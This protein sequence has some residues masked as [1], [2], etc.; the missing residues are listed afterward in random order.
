VALPRPLEVSAGGLR[1]DALG[2]L[3]A[4]LRL[5]TT[6]PPG[7]ER[8]AAELLRRYLESAGVECRLYARVHERASLVARLPGRDREAPRLLL[9]GHTDVVPADAAEWSVPPFSGEVRDGVAWGRGA[10]D[11]KGQLAATATVVAALARAGFRPSGD[12]VLAACADEEVGAGHGLAWLVEEHPD[13]VRTAWAVDEGGGE[14]VVVDGRAVWLC[15]TAEKATGALTITARGRSGHASTPQLADNALL[16]A[17]GLLAR[18]GTL[19][20]PPRLGPETGPLLAALLGTTSPADRALAS[21]RRAAPDLAALVAPMLGPTV[22]PT[23]IAASEAVNVVPGACTVTCD[24]RLL[25]GQ[26]WAEVE[27]MVRAVLGPDGYELS[28]SGP[29][30]GTRSP[31]RTPLWSA[32]EGFVREEEP[33]AAVA[34]VLLP[35]FTDGHWLRSAFDT[36]VY[37]FFPT[38]MDPA[39]RWSLMHSADERIAV[40]DLELGARFLLHAA[41]ALL[42][43]EAP[44]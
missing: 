15:S 22:T 37:G 19:S 27:A 36:V 1:D 43:P 11:M 44:A 18:L 12:L 38:R 41:V 16:R 13:A 23:T 4:L 40:D 34:P 32:V 33:G 6:N 42:G 31:L 21:L 24:C 10:L 14:R 7:N 28:W 3:S 9:L 30:G 39:A 17:A 29:S 35:G 5:D 25:P 2:L 20:P 26:E 8:A